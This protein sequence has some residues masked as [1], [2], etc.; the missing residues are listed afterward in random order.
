METEGAVVD[1]PWCVGGAP[2]TGREG[3]STKALDDRTRLTRSVQPAAI[4]G[5]YITTYLLDRSSMID[6][7]APQAFVSCTRPARRLVDLDA[8]AGVAPARSHCRYATQN[9]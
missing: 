4:A 7:T 3:P 8:D 9:E 5:K 1:R 2:R 6:T